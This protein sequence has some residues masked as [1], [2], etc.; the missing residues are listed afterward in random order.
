MTLTAEEVAQAAVERA[1]EA[2]A[3]RVPDVLP[4]TV[5]ELLGATAMVSVD[6]SGDGAPAVPVQVLSDPPAVDQ[7][8]MVLFVPPMGAFVVGSYGGDRRMLNYV[9]TSVDQTGVSAEADLVDLVCE[10]TVTQPNRLLMATCHLYLEGDTADRSAYVRVRDEDATLLGRLARL[11]F[12][13][14]GQELIADGH[15]LIGDVDDAVDVGDHA[16][17]LTLA[18]TGGTGNVDLLA[19]GDAR[20]ATFAVWDAGPVTGG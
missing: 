4:G 14:A 6:G 3:Q 7:R 20:R 11:P 5:V 1:L 18:L 15:C 16:W 9:T 13:Y 12:A 8:V 17:Q 10:F 19:S 2:M